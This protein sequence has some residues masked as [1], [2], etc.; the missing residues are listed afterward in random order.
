MNTKS[1]ADICVEKARRLI[2]R[3]LRRKSIPGGYGRVHLEPLSGH[4]TVPIIRAKVVNHDK[5]TKEWRSHN[6][7][8]FAAEEAALIVPWLCAA[9]RKEHPWTDA[10]PVKEYTRRPWGPEYRWTACANEIAVAK[11]E[12]KPTASA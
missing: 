11:R 7:L 9:A 4:T 1:I 8:T 3:E 2:P 6:E 5:E 10:L 12:T